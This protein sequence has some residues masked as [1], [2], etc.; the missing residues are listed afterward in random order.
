MFW[1]IYYHEGHVESKKYVVII[2][3][4]SYYQRCLT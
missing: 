1:S 2:E 4:D 3:Y